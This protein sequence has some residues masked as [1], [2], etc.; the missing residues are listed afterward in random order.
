[1]TGALS[2]RIS[3][4][5]IAAGAKVVIADLDQKGADTMAAELGGAQMRALGVAVDVTDR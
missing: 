5:F 3:R 2:G 1:M 4:T